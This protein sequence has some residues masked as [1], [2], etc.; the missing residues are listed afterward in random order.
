MANKNFCTELFKNLSGKEL[1]EY[2]K[3][4]FLNMDSKFALEK[5]YEYYKEKLKFM[6]KNVKIGPGVRFVNPE[7]VSLGDNV[8]IAAHCTF[9]AS[10]KEGISMDEGSRLMYGV[11]LD[12]ETPDKGYIK[13]GERVYIGAGTCLH[14]HSGLEIGDDSLLA[15]NITITP[16]SHIFNDP[17]KTIYSQGG[18]TRKITLGRDCYLGMNVSVVFSAETIGEGSVIGAG[19]VVVKPIP[20]FSVAVGVPAKV[21]KKRGE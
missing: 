12:T 15:Q 18:H 21:I 10:S 16:S 17:K 6:G 13:I 19:S 20:P 9:V 3:T 5:R 14:G 4:V 11:Y 8:N 1:E 7:N 2:H